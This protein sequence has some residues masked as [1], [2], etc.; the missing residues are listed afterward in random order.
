MVEN[1]STTSAVRDEAHVHACHSRWVTRLNRSTGDPDYP[2]EW[3]SEQCGGC[4][5]YVPLA[6][7]WGYDWGVCSNEKSQ[8]DQ[9]AVFE[10]DGCEEFVA[11]PEGW[12][13]PL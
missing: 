13:P 6:G 3:F 2:E 8:V 7:K 1:P 11:N 5:F 12:G 9:R 10:H 4:T